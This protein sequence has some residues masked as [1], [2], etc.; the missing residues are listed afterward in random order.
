[1]SKTYTEHHFEPRDHAISEQFN[2][3]IRNVQSEF[4]G[5]LDAQQLPYEATTE[6]KFSVGTS[7][8]GAFDTKPDGS[9]QNGTG[10]IH[11]TQS[12]FDVK[13]AI[14]AD[15][16]ARP[17]DAIPTTVT[18]LGPPAAAF[19]SS[20]GS[21]NAGI[22]P[23]SQD[24]DD[25]VFMRIPTRDG[26]LRGCACVDLE[27][28]LVKGTVPGFTATY[29]YNWRWQ[30]Y[31]FV[32]NLMVATTGPQPAGTRKSI[33]LPFSVPVPSKNAVEV[34]IRWSATFDGAGTTAGADSYV[35]VDDAE[36]NIFNTYLWVR[37]QTR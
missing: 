32:D 4:N 27:Y 30:I 5:E 11:P 10:H 18:L 1:M 33:Q 36:V 35:T 28:S 16:W 20:S 31:V 15:G 7:M 25:G 34:D 21:W 8:D 12:Y 14:V 9:A 3:E 23:L 13:S 29:G 22:L 19:I 26:M 37:N 24:I 17:V 2:K 6:A